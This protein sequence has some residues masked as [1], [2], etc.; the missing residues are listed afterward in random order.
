MKKLLIVGVLASVVML[1]ACTQ[2]AA[3][4]GPFDGNEVNT[5]FIEYVVDKTEERLDLTKEQRDQFKAIVES[6][7]AKALE[8]RPETDAL[9]EKMADEIRKPQLD[10]DK[11]NALIKERMQ[12]FRIIMEEEKSDFVAFHASLT[13]K[14]REAL[15]QL[16]LDHGKKGWHGSH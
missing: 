7:T 10:T 6:M 13:A 1:G 4:K 16:V 2:F 3:M 5:A 9:R 14:Q 12:L 11:L 8:Q 15:A